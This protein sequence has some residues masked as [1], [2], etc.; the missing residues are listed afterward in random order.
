M[1]DTSHATDLSAEDMAE[2]DRMAQSILDKDKDR[3]T[4]VMEEI[5]KEEGEILARLRQI[6]I[7]R[8]AVQKAGHYGK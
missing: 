8:A 2:V 6:R 1:T 4:R 3:Y 7:R 5:A